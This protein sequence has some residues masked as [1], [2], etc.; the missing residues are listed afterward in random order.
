MGCPAE[1]D[2]KERMR[3]KKQGCVLSKRINMNHKV[4]IGRKINGCRL[5]GNFKEDKVR[6]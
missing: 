2:V 5:G 4:D 1:D 6:G 3:E